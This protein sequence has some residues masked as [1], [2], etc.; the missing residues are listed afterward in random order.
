MRIDVDSLQAFHVHPAGLM[1]H[2][3]ALLFA[4]PGQP[5]FR[6]DV[7]L[8]RVDAE[9]QQEGRV[10]EGLGKE[11]FLVTDAGKPQR[12]LH[13]GHQDEPLDVVLL[14]DVSAET[15][16]AIQRVAEAA[17]TVLSGL[18]EGDRLAVM[19]SGQTTENCK[20]RLVAAM[21]GDFDT[22]ELRITGEVQQNYEASS[23]QLFTGIHAA[24]QQFLSEPRADRRRA[25]V[26]VTDDQGAGT[27]P[28]LVEDTVHNLWKADVVV[29][30]VIVHSGKTTLRLGPPHRAAR[31]AAEVTG[32]DTLNSD[33][34]VEGLREIIERLR[35]RYS[36]DYAMPQGKPG[37][38]KISV[39]LV[40]S[41]AKRYPRVQLRARRGYIVPS[42]AP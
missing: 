38:R 35:L 34:P 1:F 14:F 15:R 4:A 28:R 27:V 17:H 31:Y 37:E 10:V 12:I 5:T 8:V 2:L 16:L 3:L 24:A 23:C 7:T 32:G 18:R 6:T 20:A 9:V 36:F 19:T 41:A 22:A 30:G 25:I 13:F 21:S 40:S 29:L 33:N 39:K 42:P 11:S 26:V